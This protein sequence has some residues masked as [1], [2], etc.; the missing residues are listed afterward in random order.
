MFEQIS[1]FE[2]LMLEKK[3]EKPIRL[4]SFFSGIEAQYKAL[5]YLGRK[6]NHPVESYKTCEWA[7]NNCK[8]NHNLINI[9][10][11]HGRDLE[12]V[13]LDKYEYI[14]TYSFPCQDLSIGGYMRGMETSQ[15]EGGTRSGLLWEV[16]RILG[17]LDWSHRPQILLM[18][19]VPQ[20]HSVKDYPQFEKWMIRLEELGY[21]SYWADLNAKDYGIPQ[22]RKR[23]FMVSLKKEG[24]SEYNF[25]YPAPFKRDYNLK[26]ML[27]D[28]VADKY[29]LSRK[30]FDYF[31]GVNQKDSKYNRNKVFRRNF[32]PN[33]KVAATITTHTG[34]RPTDNFVIEDK[35]LFSEVEKALFTQD[36]NI[37]RYIGSDQ[38]DIFEE[39]DMA[40]TIYPKGYGHGPRTHKKLSIT[41]NTIDRPCVKHHLRIR[42]LT[43]KEAMRLMGFQDID[44][45]HMREVAS[46]TVVFHCAGDSIVVTVLI[47]IFSKLLG[48]NNEDTIN[49]IKQYVKEIKEVGLND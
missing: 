29:Y 38:I 17:E 42:K 20:I 33:K 5:S 36:G 11:V 35:S 43:P 8:A 41:L 22:N 9:M 16:E 14:I 48:V 15:K 44:Y 45:M 34:S 6:L 32:N 1:L 46:D 19:N 26:D 23:T 39:G 13:D 21:T 31:T 30:L 24:A 27:E 18:E 37:R 2:D 28:K 47:G 4:I 25:Y 3:I 10:D 12:I 7:Y 49:L 40:T